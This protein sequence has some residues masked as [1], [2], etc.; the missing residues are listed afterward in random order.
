MWLLEAEEKEKKNL[1]KGLITTLSISVSREFTF[2]L[3]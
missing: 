2:F 3:F 1:K